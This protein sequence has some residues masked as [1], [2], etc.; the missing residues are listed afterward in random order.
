MPLQPG[1]KIPPVIVK[2]LA[3][4]G[5]QDQRVEELFNGRKVVLFGVPGAF[6][7]T[8]T[9]KH[10]P[11]Y[12][13]ALPLF[14]ELGVDVACM[15]VN[16][17]FVMAAWTKT[18][19]GAD[20]ITLVADGNATLARALGVEMDGAGYGLGIRCQRFALYAEN[21]TIRH[22]AVEKPG[23]FEASSAEA[24]LRYLGARRSA[25]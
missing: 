8:C 17:P 11:G 2:K 14:R 21:G 15:A 20:A 16:D 10:L 1:D 4:T 19:E 6:T 13:R 12:V 7:P 18:V 22:M 5:L 24:L 9:A 3:D 23:M 25:A